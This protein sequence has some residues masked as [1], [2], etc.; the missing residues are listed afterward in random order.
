M[1]F[2]NLHLERSRARPCLLVAN[3]IENHT[4]Y[5]LMMANL[6]FGGRDKGAISAASFRTIREV[7]FTDC[8]LMLRPVFGLTAFFGE[9]RDNLGVCIC[10]F[11]TR[12]VTPW[13]ESKLLK[14]VRKVDLETCNRIPMA[15]CTLGYDPTSKEHKVV[16]IW[17]SSQPSY[18]VC[19]VL[20][21]GDNKWRQIDE[22]PPYSLELHG[23]SIHIDGSIYYTI[24]LLWKFETGEK[25]KKFIVAFDVGNEKFRAIRVPNYI[26]YIFEQPDSHHSRLYF[27]NIMLLELDERLGL[28]IILVEIGYS[29]P[30]KLWVLDED[31]NKKNS[32]NSWIE[33]N[34]QLPY[35]LGGDRCDFASEPVLG[36]KQIILTSYVKTSD[37]RISVSTCHSYNWK[38]KAFNEIEF[39]GI[40][41]D[42]CFSRASTVA[43][44][45]E[46]LLPVQ[47]CR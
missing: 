16:G 44:F 18:V 21:V 3:L 28:L 46:S 8:D 42:P 5:Q 27:Y 23:S 32:R 25:E 39:S 31:R 47:K 11:S 14:D 26:F 41:S 29:Y 12:E 20:I 4:R 1:A 17:R 36:T 13:I 38:K 2:I 15:T 34:I 22:V 7:Y 45:F 19:D 37:G 24:E 33:V 30:P 6:V 9:R 43:T 10:N 40:S 35:A